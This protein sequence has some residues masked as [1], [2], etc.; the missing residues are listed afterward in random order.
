MA[1]MRTYGHSDIQRYLQHK[2]TPQEMHAFEKAL[3]DD[4]FL[5]DA[6]EGFSASNAELT[7]KHLSEIESKLRGDEQQAKVV[8]M[9]LQKR[10]WWKVAAVVLVVVTGGIFSYSLLTRKVSEKNVAQQTIPAEAKELAS[11]KAP[12]QDKEMATRAD[13]IGPVEKPLAQVEVFR[14]KKSIYKSPNPSRTVE[15]DKAGPAMAAAPMLKED[16]QGIVMMDRRG[17]SAAL[18]DKNV[19]TSYTMA[20]PTASSAA[21]AMSARKTALAPALPGYEFKGRVLDE[22]GQPVSGASIVVRNSNKGT[23]ADANGNFTLKAADSVLSVTVEAVGSGPKDLAIRS[24]VPNNDI[25]ISRQGQNLSEA[26]VTPLGAPRILENE[27]EAS[28][29]GGWRNFVK[30]FYHERD[31]LRTK[32]DSIRTKNYTSHIVNIEFSLDKYGRPKDIKVLD[33]PDKVFAEKATEILQNG[34]G[35]KGKKNKKVQIV[36]PF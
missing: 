16:S 8:A 3:M 22:V 7:G 2:M 33:E 4:P 12:A 19:D 15:E 9:P 25:I 28:P 24:N 26:V 20:A 6:L 36:L 23:S 34:P 13:S 10:A 31:S 27:A 14:K 5:A 18:M 32:R 30:Y 29:K 35:W 11:Q 17:E 1:D 21:K